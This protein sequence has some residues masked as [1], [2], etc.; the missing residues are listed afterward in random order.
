MAGA[1]KNSRL[2]EGDRL[3]REQA[4]LRHILIYI[5]S[6]ETS[7]SFFRTLID[8]WNA[9]HRGGPFLKTRT[10]SPHWFNKVKPTDLSTLGPALRKM[11]FIS[12]EAMRILDQRGGGALSKDHAVPN[13][14]LRD[15]ILDERPATETAVREFLLAW[16]R[17]GVITEA[18][19][20]RLKDVGCKD[21]MPSNWSGHHRFARYIH[22]KIPRSGGRYPVEDV[23][24]SLAEQ[25]EAR[26][27]PE[28]G[29]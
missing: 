15:M 4:Y 12:A 14:L 9:Y 5:E 20:A 29:G 26:V 21:C 24:R 10:G 22:A 2:A 11:D 13:T 3:R 6:G 8:N 17:L 1:K 18:E 16:Y 19:H 28:K 25:A 27:I 23:R 7:S